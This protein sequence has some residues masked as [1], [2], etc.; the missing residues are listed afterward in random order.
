ML[1]RLLYLQP[2]QLRRAWP[3][4]V[5]YFV[6]FAALTLADGLSLALVVA[7]SGAGQLPRLQAISAFFVMLA[8]G[9][10]LHAANRLQSE[11]IFLGILGGPMILFVSIGI[12][13]ACGVLESP[14][15][16]LLFLGREVLFVLVLLHFGAYLQDYFLRAELDRVMPVIYAGG[17]VGGIAGGA[18]L[19]HG[20]RQAAPS[21]LLFLVAAL[22]A[23][24]M[25]GIKL[26]HLG[27]AKVEEPDETV[28]GD[29]APC[30]ASAGNSPRGFLALL[31]RSP[32]LFWIT[33]S[34]AALFFCRSGLTLQC[35]LCFEK[36]FAGDAGLAQ[37]LGRYSQIALAASLLLQLG[38]VGRLVAW[39]GLR[40]A[41]LVYA[42]M[43][44]AAAL[45][46]WGE[47]TLA[48]AVFAR[49]VEGELRYGLRNPLAQ[50]TVNRFPKPIRTQVRAWSLGFLI[51][52]ATLAASL[53]LELLMRYGSLR[54]VAILT[55][56]A[57]LAYLAAS[58][59]LGSSVQRQER[60]SPVRKS[61]LRQVAVR[62]GRRTKLAAPT[63]SKS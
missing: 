62:R 11:R 32:L 41:Q 15:M 35:S 24:G 46:G 36:E 59:G 60:S 4:F 16:G 50:M 7:R 30:L 45:S 9:G 58:V 54:G 6:L 12:G 51:P 23:A 21:L 3:F 18:L 52:A 56:A 17:R 48:A 28:T 55:I 61:I 8:V 44:A 39:L 49:F 22:L 1:S 20:S 13:L 33:I 26:I 27:A 5:L 43:I 29:P 25:V 19:E 10:Y 34:T 53:G 57:S 63:Y 31:W 37:F 38:V 47:M 42:A 2:G 14:G 40:G